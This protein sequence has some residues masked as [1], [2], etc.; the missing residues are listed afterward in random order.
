MSDWIKLREEIIQEI[1]PTE[2]EKTS[3]ISFAEKVL[4]EVNRV[5]IDSSVNATAEIHGS[6]AHD[7]W[8]KGQQDL[9]I[10]IIIEE[11]RNRKQLQEALAAVK[12]GTG[13]SFTEAYAEHP[14]LQTEIEGYTIDIVPCFR[15]KEGQKLY[16][17]TDRTPLHTKWLS[18]KL[19][20][21]QDDVRLLKK[22]L[23]TLNIY[24]AEIKVGGFSGYLCELLVIYY[25]GFLS[26]IEAAS[27][28]GKEEVISFNGRKPKKNNDPLTVIDPVDS[29]RNVASALREDSYALF[30]TAARN[31]KKNPRKIFFERR[32]YDI[33][34]DKVLNE[35]KERPTDILFL[36]IEEGH[37]DVPDT[38]WGQIHKSR[39]SI[40]RQLH[41]NGFEVLR[42]TSWSNEE[43]R[44]I[45]IYELESAEI[46]KAVKHIGPPAYLQNNVAEFIKTYQDNKR[47][48]A[49]PDLIGDR[50]YVLIEKEY[51]AVKDLLENLLLDGG[52]SVGVS[53]KLALRILQ[54]H[55]IL[56][57]GEIEDY[58]KEEDFKEHLYDWLIGRPLWIE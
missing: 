13:W 42:S 58:L 51:T 48:I 50:W 37:A 33:S 32:K 1:K 25:S 6:V 57:N 14:Y 39:K 4:A 17:S 11:Y 53:R 49:G 28:W 47:T 18:G 3:L 7:T 21:L 5:L 23:M 45:F 56:L 52:R 44:H 24:G 46:P 30:I 9:D 15:V 43:N 12:A 22:F 29:D 34:I 54:H 31:F 35:I 38:L 41:E 16:S 10:F 20:D 55:R 27:G 40:E 8:I 19:D 36:I 26:L 2:L